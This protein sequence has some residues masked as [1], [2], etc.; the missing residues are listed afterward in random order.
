MSGSAPANDNSSEIKFVSGSSFSA[1]TVT[2]GSDERGAVLT[3]A[4]AEKLLSETA[5]LELSID[6]SSGAKGRKANSR[7]IHISKPCSC[8]TASCRSARPLQAI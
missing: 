3:S 2:C 7:K 5:G 8:V 4:D 6:I 1:K